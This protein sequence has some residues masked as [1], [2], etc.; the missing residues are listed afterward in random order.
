MSGPDAMM[1]QAQGNPMMYRLLKHPD[2]RTKIAAE[3]RNIQEPLTVK[4]VLAQT[5]TEAFVKEALR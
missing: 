3:I 1:L 2:I 5:Y 4:T